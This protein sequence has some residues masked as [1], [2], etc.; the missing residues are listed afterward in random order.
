MAALTEVQS[1]IRDQAKTWIR[2]ESPV[3]KFRQMRDS[4]SDLRYVP[5]TWSGMIEMGWPGII[6]PEQYGGSGLGYLTFSWKG[7]PS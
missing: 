4:G 6:I 1:M 7:S 3:E 2:E 5:E